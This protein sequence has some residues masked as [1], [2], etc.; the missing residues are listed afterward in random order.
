MDINSIIDSI[1]VVKGAVTVDDAMSRLN[2]NDEIFIL[3]NTQQNL[4]VIRGNIVFVQHMTVNDVDDIRITFEFKGHEKPVMQSMMLAG[5][6]NGH[7]S[8]IGDEHNGI[9][10]R[11]FTNMTDAIKYFEIVQ[12]VREINTLEKTTNVSSFITRLLSQ[13]QNPPKKDS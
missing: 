3:L 8:K 9:L 10:T 11:L 7:S 2:V 12:F 13:R 6:L 1:R 5:A 4:A